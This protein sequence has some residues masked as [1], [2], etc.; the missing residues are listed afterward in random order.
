MIRNYADDCVFHGA[1]GMKSD[2][3]VEID[4]VKNLIQKGNKAEFM[5]SRIKLDEI[6]KG[7]R[8]FDFCLG[9]LQ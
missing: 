9:R 7:L 2:A 1:H 4:I 5:F 6:R 8:I 3:Q